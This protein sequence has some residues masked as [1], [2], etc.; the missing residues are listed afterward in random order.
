[1]QSASVYGKGKA[2]NPLVQRPEIST[3]THR[4]MNHECELLDALAD[5]LLCEQCTADLKRKIRRL[6][7]VFKTYKKNHT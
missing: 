2:I 5:T 1:M 7:S 4:V 6:Q 3:F